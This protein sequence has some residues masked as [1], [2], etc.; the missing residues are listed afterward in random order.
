MLSKTNSKFLEKTYI[1][2]FFVSFQTLF[3]PLLFDFHF[4]FSYFNFAKFNLSLKL[5]L[6][7]D[8]SV[9][10]RRQ[11]TLYSLPRKHINKFVTNHQETFSQRVVYCHQRLDLLPKFFN[12]KKQ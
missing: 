12:K 5:K 1:D 3:L 2:D 10:V 8:F 7:L 4:S 11:K 9:L 6:N